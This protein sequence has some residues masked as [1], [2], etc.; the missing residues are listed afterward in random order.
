MAIDTRRVIKVVIL[1]VLAV[2][3]LVI[4][5]QLFGHGVGRF[6]LGDNTRGIVVE[7]VI[8]VLFAAVWKWM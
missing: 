3:S 5:G 4:F 1:L 8:L 7:A 2:V 6:L